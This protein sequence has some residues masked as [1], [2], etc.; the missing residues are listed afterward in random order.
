MPLTQ[1]LRRDSGQTT[2][3]YL[4]IAGLVTVIA[5]GILGEVQPAWRCRLAMTVSCM[6]DEYDACLGGSL[7]DL[8][9]IGFC[10]AD[11]KVINPLR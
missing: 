6:L 2:T 11:V 1:R 7:P 10:S 8:S 9:S 3:E 5:I 4:M